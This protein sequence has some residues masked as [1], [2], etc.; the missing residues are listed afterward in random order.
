MSTEHNFSDEHLNAFVD[1]QLDSAERNRVVEALT[2][3]ADLSLKI[4]E[5]RKLKEL[6]RY[7][8]NTPI[9]VRSTALR[10][11]SRLI[12]SAVAAGLLVSAAAAGWYWHASLPGVSDS[13]IG[14]VANATKKRGVV[15]QISDNDPAK[16][17]IAL[18]N[19]K[20]IRKEFPQE[21]MDIEIVAYG[22]GLEMFKKDSRVGQQLDDAAKAGV[23]LLACG[24][25]MEFTRT[26]QD[27]LN[28]SVEVVKA[29]VVEILQKQE[30]GYSYIRP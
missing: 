23:K 22:P 17:D 20:N 6:V 14:V 5:I 19:A 21:K 8:Y 2:R 9:K 4:N 7:A 26:T 29:G 1:D 27:Q 16:W 13:A 11:P 28:S 10:A 15:M 24:N 25:T 30:Q 18:I 3:D 12:A